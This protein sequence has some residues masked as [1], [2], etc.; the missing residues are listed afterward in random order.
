MAYE[1]EGRQVA[2]DLAR[3]YGRLLEARLESKNPYRI[4]LQFERGS[5]VVPDNH[6]F[7]FGYGGSGPDC[8]H[9]FL[10]AS[11]FRTSLNDVETAQPG[12]ILRR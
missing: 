9:A 2:A 7:K 6:L 1:A 10:E 5:W 12:T 3:R 8:F 4:V 11:G